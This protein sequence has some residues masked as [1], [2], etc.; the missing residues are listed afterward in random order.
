[1]ARAYKKRKR[2][3]KPT[4]AGRRSIKQRVWD[5]MRRN[6]KFK[7]DDIVAIL[8]L[9]KETVKVMIYA[10]EAAGMIRRGNKA[11]ALKDT[12]FVFVEDIKIVTAPII[13]PKEVY[14]VQR[15]ISCKIEAKAILKRALREKSMNE[16]AKDLELAKSTISMIANAKYPNPARVYEKILEVYRR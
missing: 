7:L 11:W 10:Y 4:F 14:C 2:I 1:M 3:V 12:L 9:K 15:K 6:R 8:D 13:T 16:V 5:F